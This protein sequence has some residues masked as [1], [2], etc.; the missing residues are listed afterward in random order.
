MVAQDQRLLEELLRYGCDTL[1]PKLM[2]QDKLAILDLVV[3]M[4]PAY[5][6][7]YMDKFAIDF[8]IADYAAILQDISLEGLI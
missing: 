4:Q 3:R 5:K 1:Y 7:K 2:W 6:Q 8:I